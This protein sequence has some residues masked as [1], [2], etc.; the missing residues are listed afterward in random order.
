M[1]GLGFVDLS[2]RNQSLLNKWIWRYGEEDGALWK[3]LI[4]Q[5]YGGEN[6]SI[7]PALGNYRNFSNMWKNIVKPLVVVS[8][9]NTTLLDNIAYTLGNGKHIRF[10]THEW[11][12]GTVLKFSFPRIFAL[13]VNKEGVVADFGRSENGKWVWD[14]TL[15][16]PVFNWEVTQWTT[17]LDIL[18]DYSVCEDLNDKLI[19]KKTCS[20]KYYAKSF[21]TTVSSHEN[22]GGEGWLKFWKGL[23]PP[24]VEIFTGSC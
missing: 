24:K 22:V 8:S 12:D 9:I 21:S 16:R 4:V 14:V 1:G 10:W 3:N 6:T 2:V 5:K 19:W 23:L 17:F 20:G 13:A 18:S 11:I 7:L 15:R